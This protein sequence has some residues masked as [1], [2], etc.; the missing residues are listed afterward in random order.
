MSRLSWEP[1]LRRA[2]DIVNGYDTGV[3]LRQLFYRL[4]SES[5]L[6]NT[7][8]AYKALSARTAQARRDRWFP[9]LVDNTR[10]IEQA[11]SFQNPLD[12]LTHT[13]NRYRL[14]RSDGQRW[15]IY[16]GIEKHALAGLLWSWFADLGV[17]IVALGGYS[18]QTLVDE[19][20]TD[21][22]AD[23]RPAVMIYAGDLDPSGEDIERDFT[24][25]TG[26]AFDKVSRIA[27][28]TQQVNDFDL[29]PQMGKIADA[30]AS[31]FIAKHGALIQVELDSLPPEVLKKLYRDA[32]D[33]LWDKSIFDRVR[34][35]EIQDRASLE[36]HLSTFGT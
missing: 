9:A 21:V 35:Q 7:P 19:V 4:V 23:G 34:N 22:E 36:R 10:Q 18:S 32:I 16:L 11:V 20:V 24:E 2:A 12:A 17:R 3:T 6:P 1:I 28:T 27:L 8:S 33:A 26:G 5:V 13:L 25:R 30:R 15:N 29:P 31:Q 14:D